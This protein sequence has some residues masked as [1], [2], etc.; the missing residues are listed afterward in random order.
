MKAY[1]GLDVS[2]HIFVTSALAL[3]EWSASRPAALRPVSIG[4]E[5]GWTPEPVWTLWRRESSLLYRDSNS[6]P[7]FVQ[8]VAS[9]YTD[10]AIPA[11]FHLKETLKLE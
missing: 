7:S 4:Y 5:V 9:L 8:P 3:T 1:G 11:V 2:I 10:Y 6:E